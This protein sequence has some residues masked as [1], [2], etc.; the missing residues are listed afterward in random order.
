MVTMVSSVTIIT[1]NIIAPLKGMQYE[2]PYFQETVHLA[3]LRYAVTG[4]S[5]SVAVQ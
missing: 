1:Q 4:P 2:K 3:I 5:Q